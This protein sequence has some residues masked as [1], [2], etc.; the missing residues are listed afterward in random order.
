MAHR[1]QD[2]KHVI[3]TLQNNSVDPPTGV[4]CR[5]K[6]II[7]AEIH[8]LHVLQQVWD[9]KNIGIRNIWLDLLGGE[10]W[11]KEKSG[12]RKRV[13]EGK[14]WGKEKSGGRKRVGEGKEWGKSGG[15]KRVGEGKEWGKEKSGGRKRVGRKRVGEGKEWGKE[16]SGGR[17][18]VGEGKEWG[19]EKSG[20]RKR[21]GEGKEW[22]KE[23][24]GERKRVGGRTSQPGILRIKNT[25]TFMSTHPQLLA[26]VKT[27]GAW[28]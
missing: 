11:G 28:H 25:S 13:G 4:V 26:D 21:V 22:G 18:R 1:T 19:K 17:K 16:K 15:R 14:E 27:L 10:E 3:Y 5:Q 23:K 2:Y 24:S 6:H 12:G 9:F 7:Q 8:K 20:G